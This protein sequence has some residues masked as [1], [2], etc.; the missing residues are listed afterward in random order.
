VRYHHQ[1]NQRDLPYA[2][3]MAHTTSVI[4]FIQRARTLGV[5]KLRVLFVLIRLDIVQPERS[6][7]I[8]LLP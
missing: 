8:L 2:A 5:R 7:N 6:H 1:R 4:K 3:M